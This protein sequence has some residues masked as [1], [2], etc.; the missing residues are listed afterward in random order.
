MMD[1]RK[2]VKKMENKAPFT[3]PSLFLSHYLDRKLFETVAAPFQLKPQHWAK[4]SL[5]TTP[6]QIN[7]TTYYVCS[8]ILH[9]SVTHSS[10]KRKGMALLGAD[11]VFPMGVVPHENPIDYE[12]EITAVTDVQAYAFSYP[13]L[14]RMC[15]ASGEF[16]AQLLEQNC[17]FVGTIF[18]QEMNQAYATAYTRVCDVLYLYGQVVSRAAQEFTLTQ[19]ELAELA[20]TSLPQLER[21]LKSLRAAGILETSRMHFVIKDPQRLL[22]ECSDDFRP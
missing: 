6:G 20:G 5:L 13:V 10:G 7:N 17:D 11:T 1:N 21:A 22:Q 9:L 12:M 18:Y 8:G 19:A 3:H 15:V 2:F 4:G 16:A 14:R